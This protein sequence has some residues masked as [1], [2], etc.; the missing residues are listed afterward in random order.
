[1]KKLRCFLLFLPV[2]VM[3][4]S[5]CASWRKTPRADISLSLDQLIEKVEENAFRYE[6]FS[7]KL[8]LQG[9]MDNTTF[10]RLGGQLRMQKDKA[11]WISA[12]AFLG[13]EMVR[14]KITPDSIWM[15]NKMQDTYLAE[16]LPD[17][18]RKIGLDLSFSDIQKILVGNV[19]IINANDV[20]ALQKVGRGLYRI[21]KQGDAAKLERYDILSD[22]FKISNAVRSS[23]K[24]KADLGFDDFITIGNQCIPSIIN[25][26][27]TGKSHISAV[28]TYS[29]MTLNDP[30]PMPLRI[31]ENYERVYL[32]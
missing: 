1:M 11:I 28:V 10:P 26:N 16:P 25:A 3:L 31:D 20:K 19:S 8:G 15:V 12:N 2:A 21:E 29:N 24:W 18:M 17:L 5:S 22:L 7:A 4:L 13:M 32:K 14:L 9:E 23:D 6:W 30:K 27:F